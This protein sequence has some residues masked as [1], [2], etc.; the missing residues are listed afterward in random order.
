MTSVTDVGSVGTSLR[1]QFRSVHG[2][3]LDTL[4]PTC[5]MPDAAARYANLVVCEDVII[6]GVLS[7]RTPLALSTWLGRTGLSELPPL[8]WPIDRRAWA[9]RVQIDPGGLGSYARA[10]FAIT[11][12]YL[13][14]L[15]NE[16]D[17]GDLTALVLNALLVSLSRG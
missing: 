17:R 11:D 9:C 5:I 13:A 15:A 1:C 10:V 12:T 3:L 8:A 4:S 16:L 2:L 14:T 6:N 7:A